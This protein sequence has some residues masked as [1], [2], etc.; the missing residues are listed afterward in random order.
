MPNSINERSAVSD[1]LTVSLVPE[2]P[3]LRVTWAAVGALPHT[4]GPGARPA[5]TSLEEERREVLDSVLDALTGNPP[6]PDEA[7]AC[8]HL[9]KRLAET[10]GRPGPDS[11]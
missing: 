2:P 3:F 7:A 5:N 4:G 6:D 1:E 11:A 8:R 9:L 10:A